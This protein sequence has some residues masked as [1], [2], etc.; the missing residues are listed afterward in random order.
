M[1]RCDDRRS[2][3][4]RH[5][6]YHYHRHYCRY[7][8]NC[9]GHRKIPLPLGRLYLPL[10]CLGGRIPAGN[11]ARLPS[12][13]PCRA[14][15]TAF[16]PPDCLPSSVAGMA[17][18]Q[19]RRHAGWA[20]TVPGERWASSCTAPIRS[21]YTVYL[22]HPAACSKS[23]SRTA[24]NTP[25]TTTAFGGGSVGFASIRRARTRATDAKLATNVGLAVA[26]REAAD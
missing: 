23:A 1:A 16:T 8:S 4:G 2:T 19:L 5:Y 20:A 18:R 17:W 14:E 24:P 12:R 13:D 22:R 21:E 7:P 15:T 11:A 3:D 6:H 25:N 26:G 9:S 10:P